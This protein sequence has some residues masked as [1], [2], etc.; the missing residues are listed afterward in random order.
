M[1]YLRGSFLPYSLLLT[2]LSHL[3]YHKWGTTFNLKFHFGDTLGPE[4]QKKVNLHHVYLLTSTCPACFSC[5]I[6]GRRSH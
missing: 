3:G 6:I 2:L 1:I 5:V 4:R